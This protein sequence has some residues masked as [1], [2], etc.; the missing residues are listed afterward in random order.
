MIASFHRDEI[1]AAGVQHRGLKREIHC[2]GATGGSEAFDEIAGRDFRQELGQTNSR[3]VKQ[4]GRNVG[5][6]F[7]VFETIT[8]LRPVP[9]EMPD[10]PARGEIEIAAPVRIKDVATLGADDGR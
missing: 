3:F 6:T 8:D 1:G 5:G 4:G 10:A 7:E 2:L 9:T